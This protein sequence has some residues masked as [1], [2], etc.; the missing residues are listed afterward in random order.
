MSEFT[1]LE[2]L[3]QIE[4]EVDLEQQLIEQPAP[5]SNQL[6]SKLGTILTM[7]TGE[8]SIDDYM[9]HPLNYKRN[10]GIAQ[11]LR[12]LTGIIGNLKLAIIDIGLGAFNINAKGDSNVRIYNDIE[13]N[14]IN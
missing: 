11:I 6:L 1:S 14:G 7:E 12:G 8:G 3:A 10:R 5:A 9:Q 4:K 2:D 13:G